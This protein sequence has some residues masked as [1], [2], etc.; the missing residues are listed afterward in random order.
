MSPWRASW[1][2][3]STPAAGAL[4]PLSATARSGM[5]Q[6]AALTFLFSGP[7]TRVTAPAAV[8]T[9]VNRRAPVA[10][11]VYLVAGAVVGGAVLG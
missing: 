10:H 7:A 4:C 3:R 5:G 2:A 6:G 9:L 1:E 8:E 11:P